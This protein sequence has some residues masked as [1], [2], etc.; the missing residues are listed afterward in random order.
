MRESPCTSRQSPGSSGCSAQTTPTPWPLASHLA[1]AYFQAR[2]LDEGIAMY[3]QAVAEHERVL[4]ANHPHTRAARKMLPAPLR[5]RLS[6][7]KNR[8]NQRQT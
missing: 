1:A 4:G 2:R 3:E 7:R 6:A 8:R 5:W